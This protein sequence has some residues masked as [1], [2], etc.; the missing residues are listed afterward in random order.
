MS[1]FAKSGHDYIMRVEIMLLWGKNKRILE[2]SRHLNKKKHLETLNA[3]LN[4]I[5]HLLALLGAH[6]IHHVSGL[7][8]KEKAQK[9]HVTFFHNT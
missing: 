1:K 9:M 2:Y 7:R 3:H 5:C 6:H 8:I 4:P